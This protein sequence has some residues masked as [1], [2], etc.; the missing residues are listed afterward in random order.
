MAIKDRLDKGVYLKVW[1]NSRPKR[2]EGILSKPGSQADTPDFS[3][4]RY[5]W[6]TQDV[7]PCLAKLREGGLKWKRN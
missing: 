6:I 2:S 7:F 5:I 1:T 3:P 4:G